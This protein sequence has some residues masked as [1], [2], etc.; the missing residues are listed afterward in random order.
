MRRLCCPHSCPRLPATV[1]PAT[2]NSPCPALRGPRRAARRHFV[3]KNLPGGT[4]PGREL[5]AHWRPLTQVSAAWNSRQRQQNNSFTV[6]KP[7]GSIWSACN[8][9]ALLLLPPSLVRVGALRSIFIFRWLTW[10]PFFMPACAVDCRVRHFRL[11]ARPP[12]SRSAQVE[13]SYIFDS[14]QR[15]TLKGKNLV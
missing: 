2:R 7:S 13:I 11:R 14:Y 8:P 6:A 3:N 5:P 4:S 15:N 1:P 9:G 10:P 12:L